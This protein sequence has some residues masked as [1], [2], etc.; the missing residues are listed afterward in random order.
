M[1]KA[2]AVICVLLLASVVAA[3]GAYEAYL[4]QRFAPGFENWEMQILNQP[5]VYVP[6]IDGFFHR[7]ARQLERGMYKPNDTFVTA[8][9]KG[10][11]VAL[12]TIAHTN[13]LGFLSDRPYKFERDEMKPEFR[14][15]VF[16]DSMTGVVTATRQWTDYLEKI[17]NASPSLRSLV[18][19]REF[20]VLNF[21]S[22]GMGFPSFWWAYTEKA[23][24]FDPDMLIVNYIELDFARTDP[25]Y[26]KFTLFDTKE[27]VE[28]GVH[29]FK[30]FA[31]AQPN[32]LFTLMPLLE[33]MTGTPDYSRTQAVL[34]QVPAA[35]HRMMREVLMNVASDSDKS[36]YR[37]WYNWPKVQDGHMSDKGNDIYARALAVAFGEYLAA[38][39]T[40]MSFDR[41]AV[42]LDIAT[43]EP[44]LQPESATAMRVADNPA[45]L[46]RLR[47]TVIDKTMAAR[48]PLIRS[49]IWDKL[50]NRPSSPFE[51]NPL[52]PLAAH[53]YLPVRYGPAELDVALL[54]AT[55]SSPPLSLD[56]RHCFH[57]FIFYSE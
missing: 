9:I 2:A 6:E 1:W 55:C 45:Y 42:M 33:D 32:V 34:A 36:D 19:G 50:P 48:K 3:L 28:Q 49:A 51:R 27:Q 10:A 16:G 46:A 53:G 37:S 29:L 12:K 4:A 13:N 47:Q 40:H 11:D 41:N 17:M 43:I 57:N 20:R 31:D 7:T 8:Y 35:K 52:A 24:Q 14:I 39:L 38:Q 5:L 30:R 15:A 22:P 44:D 56:N 21:G 18:Q 25:A 26:G 54:Y 23:K